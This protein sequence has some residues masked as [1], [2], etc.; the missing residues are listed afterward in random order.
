MPRP[1]YRTLLI[2]LLLTGMLV[3]TAPG[4]AT[5]PWKPLAKG[6]EIAE[7][8]L[9]LPLPAGDS[10]ITILRIN[11]RHW[12]LKILTSKEFAYKSGLSVREWARLHGLTAVINAGLFLTDHATHA[13]YM[14]T[15]AT[16]HSG[17]TNSYQSLALFAPEDATLPPFRIL[18]LDEEEQKIPELAQ[19][20]RYALQNLRLIKHPAVN[21]WKPQARSWS[22]AA[23]GEDSEGR[24]LFIYCQDPVSMHQ[25]NQALLS[26]DIGVVAAQ[27]LEGGRQA[28]MYVRHGDYEK[29][30]SGNTE[31]SLIEKDLGISGWPIPNVIGIVPADPPPPAKAENPIPTDKVTE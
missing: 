27:H 13:G 2:L 10:R 1:P 11:P 15:P 17:R 21:R 3:N 28:Q 22:E 4:W 31:V 12:N 5:E 14:K 16:T 20:Y 23:L 8:E 6:L 25:F 26:L 29:S 19:P 9:K 7:F 24:V 18:D 30:F